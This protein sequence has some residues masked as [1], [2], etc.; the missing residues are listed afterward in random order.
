MDFFYS[1][2]HISF[3]NYSLAAH[4]HQMTCHITY[5]HKKHGNQSRKNV[6]TNHMHTHTHGHQQKQSST[7]LQKPDE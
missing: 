5:T 1:I 4:A 2:P 7:Q 3:N 6:G